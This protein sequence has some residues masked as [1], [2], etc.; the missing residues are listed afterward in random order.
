MLLH[1][2]LHDGGQGPAEIKQRPEC[3]SPRPQH[4]SP[5]SP[6]LRSISL[7]PRPLAPRPGPP[8][9]GRTAPR[10]GTMALTGAFI[11]SAARAAPAP[12]LARLPKPPLLP[13]R[14]GTPP[15]FKA[16]SS[17]KAGEMGSVGSE[18]A[19]PLSLLPPPPRLFIFFRPP[20]EIPFS[21]RLFKGPP[22]RWPA[23]ARG[24]R[25]KP[26]QGSGTSQEGLSAP[27]CSPVGPPPSPVTSP[28]LSARDK[29]DILF[30]P[31]P[32]PPALVL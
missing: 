29:R 20:Q 22:R 16:D 19:C 1:N 12:A 31:P 14:Y 21:A 17:G 13:I 7:L 6:S 23:H 10:A 3:E 24:H 30:P 8:Q 11:P 9:R 26:G 32:S 4:G 2:R 15:G 18:G 27:P 5:R 28:C 25:G